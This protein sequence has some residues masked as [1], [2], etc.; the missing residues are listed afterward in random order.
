[1]G[2]D[3]AT[4]YVQEMVASVFIEQLNEQI[5]TQSGGV[6]TTFTSL[7]TT[8]TTLATPTTL[9]ETFVE[10]ATHWSYHHDPVPTGY[11]PNDIAGIDMECTFDSSSGSGPGTCVEK[12]WEIEGTRTILDTIT[13]T[14]TG[15]LVP[16][17]TLAEVAD[18]TS[19]PSATG[20][21]AA[22]GVRYA[23]GTFTAWGLFTFGVFSAWILL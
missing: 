3:G 19:S 16:Y 11:S 23:K 15:T 1:T 13:A 8:T 18:A 20:N 17:Y 2:S 12:I 5:V 21:S 9:T 7:I 4:T 22:P 14:G 6:T 10:D